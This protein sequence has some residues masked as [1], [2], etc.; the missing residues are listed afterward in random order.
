LAPRHK[1]GLA[2]SNPVLLAAGMIGYGNAQAPGLQLERLGGFVTAPVTRRAWRGHPPR[3]VELPAG[4]V[5][6]RGP[7]NPG[8]RRVIRDHAAFWR[9]SPVPVIVHVAGHDP[10]QVAAVA[11]D[12]EP[13]AG[14]AGLELD[15]PAVVGDEHGR[16][17]QELAA[18]L[19]W[20]T[21]E[22]AD[23]PLLVRLPL[24]VPDRVVQAVLEAGADAL[25]VAQLPAG[26]H[27]DL[28]TGE[29]ILGSVHGLAVAAQVARRLDELAGW[30]G[31]PLVACGGIH[32]LQDALA[33]LAL[34]ATAIQVDTAVWVDPGLPARVAA[35]LGS[36][37]GG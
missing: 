17:A 2:L 12:L 14:V 35:A 36:D 23:L 33:Y 4:L 24:E 26:L 9:H 34:G 37:G 16:E 19:V 20:A 1:L 5:W 22:A 15:V 13:L 21:R 8:S 11:G 6:Q 10:Y 32:S 30:V 7:W 28:A 18:A 3:L 29:R 25:V 27:V 31:V